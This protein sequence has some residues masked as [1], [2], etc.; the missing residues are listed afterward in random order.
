MPDFARSVLARLFPDL[1]SY[2][3]LIPLLQKIAVTQDAPGRARAI[4]DLLRY[5]AAKSAT[6][7]DDELLDLLEPVLRTPEGSRLVQWIADQ[8]TAGIFSMEGPQP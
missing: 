3:P 6:H 5:G 7:M 1:V 2:L 4:I 8:L